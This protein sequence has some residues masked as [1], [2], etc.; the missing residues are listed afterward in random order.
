MNLTSGWYKILLVI[1]LILKFIATVDEAGKPVKYILKNKLGLSERL[2]KKLKYCGKILLNSSPAYVNAP[3]IEGDLIEAVLETSGDLSEVIPENI[4]I[5]ILYEDDCLVVLNK[6]ANMVVHPTSSHYTGTVANAVMFHLASKGEASKIRPVSRLDRDT[7]GVILFAKNAYIQET[8]IKQMHSKDFTKEYRGIVHGVVES[9]S[10]TIDMPIE[11]KP[12]SIMQ[13][14]VSPAGSPAVTHFEVLESR[15]NVTFLKFI[16]ETGR[17]HQIRVHCQ[18][19]GHPL[20][21]DTLYPFL[22]PAPTHHSQLS[23]DAALGRQALH[24]FRTGF[25][26]PISGKQLFIEAPLP[27]DMKKLLEISRK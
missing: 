10:G 24:S 18:A 11:R 21:G 9:S 13:R 8:L 23:L 14:H 12:G 15:E 3:V 19:T 17:T 4:D 25:I 6:Q 27:A 20:V 5:D 2:V 22:E 26:H 16:L 7:T 1:N